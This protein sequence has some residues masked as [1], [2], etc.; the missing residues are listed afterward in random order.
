MRKMLHVWDA[1]NA[2]CVTD[3]WDVKETVRKEVGY[4]YAT[5]IDKFKKIYYTTFAKPHAEFLHILDFRSEVSYLGHW[6]RY[7]IQRIF[8]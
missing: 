3:K 6:Y 1:K 2:A 4:H 5:Q 7:T 8:M